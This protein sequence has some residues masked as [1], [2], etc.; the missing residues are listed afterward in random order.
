MHYRGL[1]T[2]YVMTIL[3]M[4]PFFSFSVKIA[5]MRNVQHQFDKLFRVHFRVAG[6]FPLCLLKQSIA[7]SSEKKRDQIKTNFYEK[8]EHKVPKNQISNRIPWHFQAPT[9]FELVYVLKHFVIK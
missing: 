7:W 3:A 5:R 4:F 8:E 1:R 6:F 9:H 2:C